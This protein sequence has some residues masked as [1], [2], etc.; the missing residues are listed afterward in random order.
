[1]NAIQKHIAAIKSGVVTKSNVIGIRKVL[2]T[3]Y[4]KAGGWSIS[5]TA[6]KFTYDEYQELCNALHFTKPV[7]SGGLFESGLRLLTSPR[8]LR[9]LSDVSDLIN[10]GIENFRLMEFAEFRHCFY[11]V[12]RAET[13]KGNFSFY[14]IPWQSGG[15]GPVL[16]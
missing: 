5:T 9:K 16:I 2:N 8:G 13:R 11:P 6:P 3:N 12:Y 14:C 7:I 1:M 4:R 10:S 15:D